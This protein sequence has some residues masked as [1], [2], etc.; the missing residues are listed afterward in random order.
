MWTIT[1]SPRF[2]DTDALGHIT[3]TVIAAWFELGRNGV[4]RIFEPDLN[5][6]CETWPLIM[7]HTDFDFVAEMYFQYDIEIRTSIS[8]IGSKS[9]TC[10][11]EAW[12]QGRLCA[13]GNAVLVHFDFK[14]KQ[15]TILPEDQKKALEAH[16][17]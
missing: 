12:Q 10:Y 11:H 5:F 15:S 14:A 4:F 3:N 17:I 9:F 8:R 16:L 13:K 2:G 1:V 6:S 7:A